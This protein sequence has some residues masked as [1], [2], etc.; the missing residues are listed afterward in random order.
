MI[1]KSQKMKQE[2]DASNEEHK[3]KMDDLQRHFENEK[4]Q[5]IEQKQKSLVDQK[6][7]YE[8]QLR[9]T[10]ESHKA[11]IW[12]ALNKTIDTLTADIGQKSDEFTKLQTSIS[13]QKARNNALSDQINVLSHEL[14]GLKA[15]KETLKQQAQVMTT[16]FET[17]KQSYESRVQQYEQEVEALKSAKSNF[18]K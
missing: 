13:D 1:Q 7:G 17:E 3:K 10:D 12:A 11:G 6:Q 16:E 9:E 8:D 15:E 14:E 5:M 18:E 2:M 4:R